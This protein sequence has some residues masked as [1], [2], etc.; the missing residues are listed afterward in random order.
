[1]IKQPWLRRPEDED[2]SC[3]RHLTLIN[4]D[5][6]YRNSR[7]AKIVNDGSLVDIDLSEDVV[8]ADRKSVV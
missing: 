5:E 2:V 1:M 6:L 3:L 4:L 7:G 8:N